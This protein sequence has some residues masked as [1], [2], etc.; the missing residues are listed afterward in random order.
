MSHI[1]A[2]CGY[3]EKSAGYRMVTE[4]FAHDD[5][6]DETFTYPACN[7]CGE[8]RATIPRYFPRLA[9]NAELG[10]K[11][12]RLAMTET[13]FGYCSCCGDH[14]A[15]GEESICCGAAVRPLDYDPTPW[16]SGCGSMTRAKCDCGPRADNE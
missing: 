8:A 1:G 6:T 12:R 2:V 3:C 4:A 11:D 9:R 14:S 15:V 13:E 5:D 10:R 7:N 16:C